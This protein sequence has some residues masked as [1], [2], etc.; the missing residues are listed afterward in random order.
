MNKGKCTHYGV[1]ATNSGMFKF[2]KQVGKTI[3]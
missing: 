3:L 1:L 2:L